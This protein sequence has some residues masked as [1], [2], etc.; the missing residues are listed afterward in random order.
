METSAAS[1]ADRRTSAVCRLG[2]ARCNFSE[3]LGFYSMGWPGPCLSMPL[4]K[5]KR[6]CKRGTDSLEFQTETMND[7][8]VKSSCQEA[9]SCTQT[10]CLRRLNAVDHD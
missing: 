3:G 2:A 9:I 4:A 5:S 6:R 10:H 1:G 7:A 8:R